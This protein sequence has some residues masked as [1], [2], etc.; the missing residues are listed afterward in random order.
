MSDVF[1]SYA[2]ED[3]AVAQKLA[4]N[5]KSRGFKV[6][7]DT[8]LVGSDDYYEVI[9]GA[10]TKARAA[11]V[12]WTKASVKSNFVRDEARF[13]LHKKKLI[14]TKSSSI[15]MDDIPFGFQGQHTE[16]LAESDKI[17][18]AIEKLGA[19]AEIK[20]EVVSANGDQ[21]SWE[22]IKETTNLETLVAFLAAWPDS[23][24]RQLATGRLQTL[25]ASGARTVVPSAVRESGAAAPARESRWSAFLSGLTFR[26]PSFQLSGRGIFS[27]VGL[28]I[29]YLILG[30]LLFAVVGFLVSYGEDNL[31]W[32]SNTSTWIANLLIFGVLV[33]PLWLQFHKWVNQ[34]SFA[35]ALVIAV[36]GIISNMMLLYA[37]YRL[38]GERVR[39]NVEVEPMV[40]I[41]SPVVIAV[42]IA[43]VFWAIRRAR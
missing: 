15:E 23:P 34:R 18:R 39:G 24:H 21:D 19:H 12:I 35:A 17:I 9:L 30:L 14:T 10:L 20:P 22:R 42:C 16:D 13:A 31:H 2:R 40:E 33:G 1:I 27:A 41:A 4:E 3:Q 26:V 36:P 11:I 38:V 28:V 32:S 43:Y 8:E 7:W 37:V 25:L 6:W 5:L 29:G